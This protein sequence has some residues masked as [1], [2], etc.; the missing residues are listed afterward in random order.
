MT[1]ACRARYLGLLT[2]S[3]IATVHGSRSTGQP[4][5]DALD[6]HI[7]DLN[8]VRR[9]LD[10]LDD[11]SL[12]AN[13]IAMLKSSDILAAIAFWRLFKSAIVAA[14]Q[15]EASSATVCAISDRAISPLA[16]VCDHLRAVLADGSSFPSM[17]PSLAI[18]D[19]IIAEI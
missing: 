17:V 10:R 16:E 11:P 9:T 14:R 19:G 18:V 5:D 12:L 13:A 2:V 3:Q 15:A 7:D 6:R 8:S 1:S 4:F